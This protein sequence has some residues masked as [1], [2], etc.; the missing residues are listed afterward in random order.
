MDE[1]SIR[2]HI[3][4]LHGLRASG[5]TSGLRAQVQH[6]AEQFGE[7]A[8]AMKPKTKPK[9]KRKDEGGSDR[10]ETSGTNRGD[11]D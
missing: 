2:K 8:D 4:A 10:Q 3:R 9:V 11:S 5:T 7:M 6:L 1:R